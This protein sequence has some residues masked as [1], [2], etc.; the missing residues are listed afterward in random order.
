MNVDVR[1]RWVAAL[2]SGDY[3]QGIGKLTHL[4]PD[5]PATYCCL[6]VLC[7]LAVRAGVTTSR[8]VGYW[9]SY[10]DDEQLNYLPPDVRAWAGLSS[11][12]PL[13]WFNAIE[14]R[15]SSLNDG[16][17]PFRTIAALIGAQL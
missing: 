10:G 15:L 14:L 4:D 16:R 9:R 5:G 11:G 3:A 13:V 1:D 7:D 12:D 6:G 17:V 2:L 8:D